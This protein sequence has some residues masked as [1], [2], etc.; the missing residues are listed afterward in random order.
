MKL[1][2][3]FNNDEIL[4]ATILGAIEKIDLN[5]ALK[6]KDLKFKENVYTIVEEFTYWLSDIVESST[7]DFSHTVRDVD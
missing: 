5:S 1:K 2:A 6:D 7:V 3:K 4:L